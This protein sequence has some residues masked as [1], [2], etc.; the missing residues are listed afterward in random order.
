MVTGAV[1]AAIMVYAPRSHRTLVQVTGLLAV[2][3]A[4]ATIAAW[5]TAQINDLLAPL[6]PI[7]V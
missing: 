6:G 1:V 7:T 3:F 5:R 4:L 2:V